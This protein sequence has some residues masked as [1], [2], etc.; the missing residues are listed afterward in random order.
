LLTSQRFNENCWR[1]LTPFSLKKFHN[2]SRNES[3]AGIVASSHRGRA[4]KGTTVHN[5]TAILD[6]FL[7]I[8]GIFGRSSYVLYIHRNI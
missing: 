4:L 2:V 8:L 3:G 6:T 1:P 5:C 7:T